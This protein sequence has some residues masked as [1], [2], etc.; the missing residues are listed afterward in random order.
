MI[1][2]NVKELAQLSM[3]EAERLGAD[4]AEARVQSSIGSGFMLKNGEPQ[5]SMMG[6]SFGI[7]IRV[8]VRRRPGFQRDEH[9]GEGGVKDLTAKTVKMAKASQR[10]VK[11]KV[12]ARRLQAGARK[13]GPPEKEK[14]EGADA[15]WLKSILLEIDGRIQKRARGRKIPNRILVAASG[16]DEKYTSTAT[17]RR[18]RAG[19]RGSTSSGSSPRSRGARS[20]RG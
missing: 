5:P 16:V 4:Y 19:S 2:E 8:L 9:H 3:R 10:L 18:R 13:F 20:P 11:K 15:A 7:G 6:D 12:E 14:V 1:K 17:G